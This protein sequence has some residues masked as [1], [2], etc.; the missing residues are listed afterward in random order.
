MSNK[1]YSGKVIT[2]SIS[3]F[4][5][6]VYSAFLA[7]MI[8]LL[9]SKYGI[10]LSMVG[11]LDVIRKV[12]TFFNPFIGLL[13]DKICLRYL[14]IFTPA[15]TAA[16]MSLL[17]LSPTLGVLLILLFVSGLSSAL[18]HIPAPILVKQYSGSKIARGM[19]FYMFGGEMA[20]TI[21]PLV[22]TAALSFWGLEGTYKL[23]PIG[24]LA[25]GILFFKLKN[26]SSI[27]RK[28]SVNGKKSI[29]QDIKDFI[30]FLI[31]V[32]GFHLFRSGMKSA[33]TLYLPTYIVSQGETLWLAGISLSVL[34]L[35]GSIGTV[36]I[37]YVSEKLSL[38]TTLIIIT[39]LCPVIMLMFIMAN[40]FFIIPLLVVLGFLLFATGPIMLT[41][42]QSI[43]TERPAFLNS[44]YMTVNFGVSSLMVFVVGILGDSLGL[45]LTFK[46]C[47]VLAFLA[48]PFIFLLPRKL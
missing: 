41:L 37:G 3:H 33:L 34:Q 46:I 1:F 22:I 19:G 5:H 47:A 4:F 13:A 9:I 45:V 48:V 16:S 40:D 2:I 30:P 6:D 31:F 14:V 21:G 7:P 36:G 12:P 27:D 24:I 32:I 25:S 35:S 39:A 20:R 42:V 28:K 38:R 8:P 11:L 43:E 29:K 23:M 10:S 44:I 26:I 18:F 15:L 17:G